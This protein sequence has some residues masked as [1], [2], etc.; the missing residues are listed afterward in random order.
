MDPATLMF[1]W[2]LLQ[3]GQQL[4]QMSKDSPPVNVAPMSQP[5][6]VDPATLHGSAADLYTGILRCYH[7][8]A[9]YQLADVVQQPWDHQAQY[10]ADGSALV[11]IRFFGKLSGNLYEMKV[12]VLSKNEPKQIRTAV[13]S[14]NAP[15]PPS[16]KCQLDR[17]TGL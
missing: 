13:L 11:R 7:P 9:R 14:D 12:G 1:L 16:A 4:N 5:R 8:S 17:W 3:T 15:F 10:E 2:H 6:T